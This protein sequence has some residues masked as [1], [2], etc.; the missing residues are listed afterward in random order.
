MA[1]GIPGQTWP[2]VNDRV[3][4]F[5]A[6]NDKR[7]RWQ[8]TAF[9]YDTLR[10]ETTIVTSGRKISSFPTVVNIRCP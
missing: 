9:V 2:T 5:T 7:L 6:E 1:V 3:R 8:F 10:R 4:L